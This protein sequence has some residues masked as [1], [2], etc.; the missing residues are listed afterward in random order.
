[1][2]STIEL[3]DPVFREMKSVA[4]QQGSSLKE[5]V[6]RAVETELARAKRSKTGRHEVKLPLVPSR[7]PGA[8]RSMTNAE[9]EDLLG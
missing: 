5:F 6:L 7:R 4:A 9:I 8:L 1:M 3:P 2:R